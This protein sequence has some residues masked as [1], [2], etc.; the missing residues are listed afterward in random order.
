MSQIASNVRINT[1][2]DPFKVTHDVVVEVLENGQWIKHAG[3]NSLSNDY[4]YS[5][6]NE[7]ALAYARKHPVLPPERV[8]T[9]GKMVGANLVYRQYETFISDGA[10]L[11]PQ[12]AYVAYEKGACGDDPHAYGA[13]PEE[14]VANLR[15][16]LED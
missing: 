16:I 4:A 12:L 10:T 11:F 13:T 15:E 14:A 7:A 9:F 8:H 2:G 1:S 6:A 5:S 3:F